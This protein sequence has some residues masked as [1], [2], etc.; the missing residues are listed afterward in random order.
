M[1]NYFF[2]S[3]HHFGHANII[4][5]CNRPFEDVQ[6]MDRVMIERWNEK[7]NT[8]DAKFKTQDSELWSQGTS[9]RPRPTSSSSPF[10]NTKY[11]PDER[12]PVSSTLLSAPA[13][14]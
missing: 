10:N 13:G 7:S 8:R 1:N 2:T 3:D 6:E 12:V 5:F 11:K 4:R 9:K 14:I